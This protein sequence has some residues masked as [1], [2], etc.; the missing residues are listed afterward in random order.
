M[1]L[2]INLFLAAIGERKVYYFSTTKIN[3]AEPHYFICL[4]R[5]DNDLLIMSCCTSQ[6]GTIKSFVE[7]RGLPFE[8]LVW[9]S[10]K[11]IENPFTKDTYVNCN[12]SKT[13]TL[14]EFKDMYNS[15][16]I[17]YSGEI[18]ENHYKQILIGI[19]SSTLID[20]ETKL[21]VPNPDTI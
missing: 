14:D 7:T 16:N 19:H 15:D 20:E 12:E 3:T 5:T 2:P 8:T 13:F 17:S 21:I 11:D 4:K 1:K 10:P 6:F 18:S 9:I